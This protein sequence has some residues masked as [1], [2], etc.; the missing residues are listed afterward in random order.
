VKAPTKKT[1]KR[2]SGGCGYPDI[3][4]SKGRAGGQTQL[5]G[6]SAKHHWRKA[7]QKTPSYPFPS[8]VVGEDWVKRDNEKKEVIRQKGKK[9]KTKR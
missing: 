4:T 9:K 2:L 6:P 8:D 1:Q 5:R 7:K 3:F